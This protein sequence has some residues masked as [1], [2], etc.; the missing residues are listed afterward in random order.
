M[1][2]VKP[3][4]D[5]SFIKEISSNGL[6]F[7]G[8]DLYFDLAEILGGFENGL[9]IISRQHVIPLFERGF[10]TFLAYKG[11]ISVFFG[12]ADYNPGISEM[13]LLSR[14]T[15]PASK[16]FIES[17]FKLDYQL[18]TDLRNATDNKKHKRFQNPSQLD[19]EKIL[20]QIFL[21]FVTLY[22]VTTGKDKEIASSYFF[23]FIL[24]SLFFLIPKLVK[25]I[26]M[27]IVKMD[28]HMIDN[29][30][31][32]LIFLIVGMEFKSFFNVSIITSKSC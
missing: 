26:T 21:F 27:A 16:A 15:N 17:Y 9:N 20:Y 1:A 18:L 30:I 7:E 24:S 11:K 28:A 14:K 12:R 13:V 19:K 32:F 5:Y 6:V 23:A 8:E 3:H 31:L 10:Q 4:Y 25:V 22:K 29:F 2:I